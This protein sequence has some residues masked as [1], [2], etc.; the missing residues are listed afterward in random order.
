MSTLNTT[1]IIHIHCCRNVTTDQKDKK[2]TVVETTA[3]TAT[4]TTASS[5]TVYGRVYLPETDTSG[6]SSSDSCDD[7]YDSD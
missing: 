7:Y 4:N 5:A 6:D 1:H 2:D 3:S